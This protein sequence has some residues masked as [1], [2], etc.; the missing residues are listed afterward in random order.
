MTPGHIPGMGKQKADA[1]DA[2][3]EGDDLA[4]WLRD[5]LKTVPQTRIE[6]A[7]HRPIRLCC[8]KLAMNANV[9][10]NQAVREFLQKHDCWP[11]AAIE[12]QLHQMLQ[13]IADLKERGKRG[14][15]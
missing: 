15:W 10:I 12:A 9:L 13:Q 11:E 4:P 7:L 6:K 2:E 5:V 14:K 3:D 8:L 1:E